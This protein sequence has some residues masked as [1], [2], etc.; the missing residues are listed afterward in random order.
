MSDSISFYD[1]NAESFF[2]TTVDVDTQSL[3]QHFLS[4]IPK[5]GDVLDAG[6]GS[7]R[8]VKTFLELDYQVTAFDGSK[9]MASMASKLTMSF[10]SNKP[11]LLTNI[12]FKL[13]KKIFAEWEMRKIMNPVTNDVI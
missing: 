3:H 1:L 11:T 10:Q 12:V 7:G 4:H 8:D 13:W 6:C 5:H 9:T 2:N